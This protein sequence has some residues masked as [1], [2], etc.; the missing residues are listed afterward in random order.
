MRSSSQNRQ[1]NKVLLCSNYQLNIFYNRKYALHIKQAATGTHKEAAAS[2]FQ[3]RLQYQ[4]LIER[5]KCHA[6]T[7]VINAYPNQTCT[8]IGTP[9]NG[10]GSFRRRPTAYLITLNNYAQVRPGLPR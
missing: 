3:N 1:E 8:S 2:K 7:H 5:S 9:D 6:Y 4:L 10:N